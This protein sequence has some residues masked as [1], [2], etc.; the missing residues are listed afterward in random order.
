MY[1]IILGTDRAGSGE[2]RQRTRPA[3]RAYLHG[4]HD[5]VVL[6]LAGPT[7]AADGKTMTGSMIVVEAQTQDAVERFASADPYRLADLFETVQIRAWNWT[8]GNPALP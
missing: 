5:G 3:H 6:R 8:T 7:L 1:F 4:T 2:L